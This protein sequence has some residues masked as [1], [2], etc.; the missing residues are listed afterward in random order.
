M[1]SVISGTFSC[2]KNSDSDNTQTEATKTSTSSGTE[3]NTSDETNIGTLALAAQFEATFPKDFAIASP[4]NVTNDQSIIAGQ[5]A[6]NLALTNPPPPVN[7]SMDSDADF[8]TKVDALNNVIDETDI[9]KCA[10]QIPGLFD[11][12]NSYEECFGPFVKAYFDASNVGQADISPGR[13]EVGMFAAYKNPTATSGTGEACSAAKLNKVFGVLSKNIDYPLTF[14]AMLVCAAKIKGKAMPEIGSSLEMADSLD[15]VNLDAKGIALTSAKIARLDDVEGR[16]VFKTEITG[17]LMVG[18]GQSLTPTAH[19]FSMTIKNIPL[20]DDNT[21]N[22]GIISF[23]IHELTD[24]NYQ[25]KKHQATSVQYDRQDDVLKYHYIKGNFMSDADN[26]PA[27]ILTA[28]GTINKTSAPQPG[29]GGPNTCSGAGWCLGYEE[30]IANFD[31]D[32]FGKAAYALRIATGAP[33]AYVFNIE[34]SKETVAGTAY[35]GNS[36]PVNT[37]DATDDTA[38][39]AIAGMRC[40]FRNNASWDLV[41]LVQKQPIKINEDDKVWTVNGE[42]KIAYFPTRDCNFDPAT[43]PD[44]IEKVVIDW[45]TV[46]DVSITS[47]TSSNLDP[48]AS[49][50]SAWTMPSKP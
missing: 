44:G 37:L 29:T 47:A 48:V 30:V 26:T 7:S 17:T 31:K 13:N 19:D 27:L 20:N 41:D 50:V 35:Y 23:I 42:S 6:V 38:I 4:T 16:P 25:D 2:K 24:S 22:K 40:N 3:T 39:F 18:V 8:Q 12:S 28:D 43:D 32:M 21:E 5:I 33:S 49:Y 14:Q 36:A 46:S 1:V 10:A 11:N 15:G 34:T 9:S 45:E